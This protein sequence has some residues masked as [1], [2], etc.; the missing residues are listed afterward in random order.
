MPNW[1][2]VRYFK[3]EEWGE[4]EKVSPNLIFHTDAYRHEAGVPCF[5]HEAFATSGHTSGSHHY[6]GRAVDL[7]LAGMSV[8]DQFLLAERL[9]F[10]GGIGV[11]PTWNN[12][13]LHLDLGGRGRRW[14]FDGKEYIPLTWENLIR[15]CQG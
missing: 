5:I 11:Y 10:F 9:G 13:G 6:H 8:V 15:T 3:K 2:N 1:E 4:W 14:I 12:P 7:H